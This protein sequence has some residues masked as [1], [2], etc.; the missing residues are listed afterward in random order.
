MRCW[1]CLITGLLLCGLVVADEL[2]PVFI[3]GGFEMLDRSSLPDF[4]QVSGETSAISV[5]RSVVLRIRARR[6]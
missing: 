4:W 6:R 2:N 3:N 1:I 5:Q